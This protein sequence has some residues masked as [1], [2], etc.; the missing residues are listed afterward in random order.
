MAIINIRQDRPRFLDFIAISCTLARMAQAHCTW[1]KLTT[2]D[3][4]ATKLKGQR[5][6]P[7]SQG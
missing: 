6:R 1:A 5:E 2:I 4:V 7:K 3:G